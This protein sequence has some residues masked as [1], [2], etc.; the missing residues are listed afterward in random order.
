TGLFQIVIG[1]AG[2]GK[3][4]KYIPY[5]VISGFLTGSAILMILS[6]MDPLSGKGIESSWE[7]WRWL[8]LFT[9]I[10]TVIFTYLGPRY[11]KQLPGTIAG[12]LFGTLL[13]HLAA[14]FNPA[15]LPQQW[16]I[17]ELPRIDSVSLE[18]SMDMFPDLSWSIIIPAALALA[19]LA[20][21]DTLLTAVIAD[22][23]TGLRH[24]ANLEMVGQGIGQMLTSVSGGMAAAGTTGATVVAVKSG[25]RRWAGVIAGLTF[26]VLILLARDVGSFLPISVLAGII[27]AVSLHMFDLDIIAWSKRRKTRQDAAIAILVTAV[28]VAYD[29]MVAVGLGVVIAIIL[30]I[31]TQ[32]RMPVVHRRSTGKHMRS[33]KW[34]NKKEREL[35]DEHGDRIIMYELRGNLFFATA[36]SLLEELADDLDKPNYVILHLRR[37]LQVDLTAI[38]FLHQIAS[39]LEKNG[40]QL[41]F[42]NVHKEIGI[43][44]RMKKTFRKV[45]ASDTDLHVLTFNG[46]DEALEHAEDMLLQD[47]DVTPTE[48]YDSVPF[49]ENEFCQSLTGEQLESL[50]SILEWKMLETSEKLFSAGD[51]GDQVYLVLSGEIDIRLPTTKHHYKRLATNHPG[52]FFGELALLN[53]GPRVADAVATHKTE[54]L[55]LTRAALDELCKTHPDTSIQLLMNLARIQVEH[56][57]WSTIELQRLSEW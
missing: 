49:E 16:L 47:Q 57:R 12:L 28:T 21:L 1:I 36:D 11:I 14:T 45:S 55:I 9:A 26:L 3:L 2:G 29:L 52:S 39:R 53:P 5:P 33:V 43:G 56:L 31:R 6:Q 37:V 8:P 51:K 17:G 20:S 10:A 35:L 15:D 27:L 54:I 4:I 7:S 50:K 18:I 34:R 41:I 13:F 25:G 22:V 19:I 48:F 40:G 24:N 23:S 30:F 38:K 46:K 42:C 32:I 44:K